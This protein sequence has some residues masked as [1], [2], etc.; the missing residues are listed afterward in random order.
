M[1][2]VNWNISSRTTKAG[3]RAILSMQCIKKKLPFT[4]T[5]PNS[6]VM[7]KSIICS[8]YVLINYFFDHILQQY[9]QSF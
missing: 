9:H 1:Q 2:A 4:K 8:F 3:E 7:K 5:A 6:K